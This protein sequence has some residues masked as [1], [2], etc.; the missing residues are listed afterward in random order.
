MDGYL[1][2]RVDGWTV[3]WID[4]CRENGGEPRPFRQAKWATFP[5]IMWPGSTPWRQKRSYSLSVRDFDTQNKMDVVK[6]YKIRT[7]DDGGFYIS[8]RSNFSTLQELVSH[9]K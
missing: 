7:L 2:E 6:H 4:G 1:N 3:E 9:Y 5:A 8:T